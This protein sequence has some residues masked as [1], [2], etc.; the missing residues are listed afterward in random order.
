MQMNQL[1]KQAK[2]MQNKMLEEQEKIASMQFAGAA[3]GDM[4]QLT[5]TGKHELTSISIDPKMLNPAEKEILED[6]IIAAYLDAKRKADT[7]NEGSMSEM[8]GGFKMPAGM[9]LPF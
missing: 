8:M 6:L 7:Q 4:V 3:G 2:A 5:I 1:L 9:K